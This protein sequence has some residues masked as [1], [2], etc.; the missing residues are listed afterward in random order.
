MNLN[1]MSFEKQVGYLRSLLRSGKG[2]LTGFMALFAFR[3]HLASKHSPAFSQSPV[4][5]W[6][7]GQ[8]A[9]EYIKGY[10]NQAKSTLENFAE[11]GLVEAKGEAE[12]AQREF[13]LNEALYPALQEVLEEVFGKETVADVVARAKFYKNP[14]ANKGRPNAQDNSKVIE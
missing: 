10:Y 11:I 8:L 9:K 14:G 4:L 7:L 5:R 3:Y 12:D 2:T 1:E 6:Y 13:H